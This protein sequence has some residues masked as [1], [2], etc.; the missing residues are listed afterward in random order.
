MVCFVHVCVCV[1]THLLFQVLSTFADIAFFPNWLQLWVFGV[2]VASVALALRFIADIIFV[3]DGLPRK[4]MCVNRECTQ[5]HKF[6][7]DIGY[8]FWNLLFRGLLLASAIV[9]S[10]FVKSILVVIVVVLA[11]VDAFF[12]KAPSDDDYLN[13]E[14]T[15]TT[16]TPTISLPTPPAVP[17]TPP[18]MPFSP[19]KDSDIGAL[20]PLS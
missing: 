6:A 9:S 18:V 15:Q 16:A 12:A 17:N 14:D 2:G 19:I 10:R 13:P 11:V 1:L 20:S 7:V 3:I 5:K 4:L 8:L